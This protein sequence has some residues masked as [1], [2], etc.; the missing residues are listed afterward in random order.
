MMNDNLIDEMIELKQ[1]ELARNKRLDKLNQK[2][3]QPNNTF[4]KDIYEKVLVED[5][6]FELSVSYCVWHGFSIYFSNKNGSK[7]HVYSV[8]SSHSWFNEYITRIY[9]ASEISNFKQ[10]ER[11]I[12]EDLS[13]LKK[14]L[15]YVD[16]HFNSDY[17]KQRHQSFFNFISSQVKIILGDD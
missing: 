14:T 11:D 17:V 10:W 9:E 1:K 6:D 4:L 7:Y 8:F 2:Y 16:E 15:E 3:R 5:D 13:G 12:K